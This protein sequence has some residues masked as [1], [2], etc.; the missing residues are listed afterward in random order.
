MELKVAAGRLT[1]R[2][3]EVKLRPLPDA[4]LSEPLNVDPFH[5]PYK[6]VLCLGSLIKHI[7]TQV[8]TGDSGTAWLA[9]QILTRLED[10]PQLREPITDLNV[11]EK[12]REVIELM[13]LTI[14]PSALREEQLFKMSRPFS[15][16][17]TLYSSKGLDKL[18]S[19]ENVGYEINQDEKMVYRATTMQACVMILNKFY[20]QSIQLDPAVLLTVND[21]GKPL[22]SYYRPEMQYDFVEV[23][24]TRPVRPLS[25]DQ[26]EKLLA[27]IY[28]T[29]LWMEYL[30]PTAF[31]FQGFMFSHLID[32]TSE[33][34]LSRLK[35]KM[36]RR[37]AVIDIENVREL[38]DLIRL[39]FNLP[40]LQ[41][42]LAAVDF[43]REFQVAHQ[44][45]IHFHL[46]SEEV[47]YLLDEKYAG[48]IYERACKYQE[49]VLIEDLRKLHNPGIL[50]KKLMALGLRGIM[51]VPLLNQEG[52]VIG[53]VELASPKS[54]E[55]HSFLEVR[56][57]AI[58][59][60]FRTTLE[61]SREDVDNRIE[62][63]IREQYTSLHPS[64]EW[65]FM[66]AAFRLLQ[67]R[68]NGEPITTETIRFEDVY[69]FYGQVDIVDSSNQRN[70]AIR[71]DLCEN[72]ARLRAVL[73][74]VSKHLRF[75]LADQVLMSVNEELEHIETG[76]NNSDESRLAELIHTDAHPLLRQLSK[77]HALL[78][79][80]IESYFASLDK[81]LDLVHDCRKDYEES[82]TRLNKELS[83]FLE[84]RDLEEQ[85]ALPHYYEQYK[86]DGVEFEMYAGQSLL[87]KQCF[88]P[89]HLRNLRLSQLIDVCEATRLVDR[90]GRELPHPLQTA[91]L[92]FAYTSPISIRFRMDEKRFDVEGAYN[93][94]YEILK[95][96]IDKATVND[97]AERLTQSG[98]IAIVYLHDK[99]R[100]EYLGYLHY[101]Q[102]SGYLSGEIEDLE[103]D[104][105]QSVQGLRA[106]RAEVVIA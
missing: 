104:A 29:K 102:R 38:A 58:Q 44:Y 101:L 19:C 5:I 59:R 63:I 60:L 56:F 26:I 34:A 24:P 94:R 53:I 46:L 12:E 92:V 61:R 11:L 82:V 2:E 41:L 22:P 95:K 67:K 45:K 15:V 85:E 25:T 10:A 6:S 69:P 100:E 74:Y 80:R 4:D 20:G 64:V 9:R 21:P 75:P 23:I 87:Q 68:E 78:S 42:G 33:E 1:A 65:R 79:A 90:L 106:L 91:Q 55:L 54:F 17:E 39:H 83:S 57:R 7:E 66:E 84:K 89:V 13:L 88:S 49:T 43:P 81:E 31:V 70:N 71:T 37:D 32:V 30:P 28:D 18:L 47:D 99:D 62:A 72:L 36:L 76:F 35:Y 73:E 52:R 16:E 50:A 40:D 48:S 27:N 98:K 77:N 97:G 8:D 86:T 3:P 51:I 14:S 105:V 103:L 96:R 93:V